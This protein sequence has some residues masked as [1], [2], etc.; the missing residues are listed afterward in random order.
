MYKSVCGSLATRSLPALLFAT[1]IGVAPLMLCSASLRAATHE[2]AL[3]N[4]LRI[5]VKEDHRAPVVVSQLWYRAGSMDEDEG[6]SG[7]AHVLEHMMFK[8]TKAVP[9]GEFSRLI[10]AA[11]GRENAFTGRD[12][13]AYFQQLEK[14]KLELS[15]KLE[16]DRMHNLVLSPE[17]FAKEI[18]VV[19]EERRLRTE[20]QPQSL[21][22]EQVSAAAF[23]VHPYRRP[24]VGWMEDLQQ[25]SVADAAFWY[26]SWYAPNNALL[27]VVG[28]VQPEQVFK[29]AKRYF[30]PVPSRVLPRRKARS[31]PVQRG[32]RQLVVKAPA[33]L[34]YLILNYH[35]PALRDVENDWEPYALEILAGI[36]DAGPS[37]R[38]SQALV[39]EQRIA[40]EAGADYDS[41]ARGPGQF[42]LEGTPSEGIGADKLAAALR[43]QIA[44]II[45]DGI[46][47]EEL[48]R[49][50][51]QVVASEVYARDSMFYQA[52][53]IGQTEIAGLPHG[54]IE[55]RTGKLKSVTAQQVQEVARKY[56]VDDN[57][58]L[59]I[60]DP[61]PLDGKPRHPMPRAMGHVR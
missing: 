26:R 39:R 33:E 37:A 13:T 42:L 38:L 20:D 41:I 3:A 57:V 54:A 61:Q 23:T 19:K 56:L 6:V 25:M 14:S 22:Y 29:L 27:V 35:V 12:Y 15:F 5:I 18:Q 40:A 58:T 59:A 36:L 2:Y 1:L 21:V 50:K 53:Q 30:D 4:G 7:V 45:N 32:A 24:I 34:P 48:N 9:A 28:D 46:S 10:A 8:G 47:E 52:M 60:L 44:L 16:A 55:R 51:A 49:V 17:E 43:E 11:G 31:E